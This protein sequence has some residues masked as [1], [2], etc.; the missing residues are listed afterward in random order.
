MKENRG[1]GIGR[2]ASIAASFG[3]A[4]AAL[5]VTGCDRPDR[6]G[7]IA[8]ERA[9]LDPRIECRIGNARQ[10]ERFCTAERDSGEDGPTLT[11]H[12]PDGGFRRLLIT[13]D[14][15]GVVAA[16]GAEP[17]QVTI[18]DGGRIEV[19]IGGDR[20]RLPATIAAQ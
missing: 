9:R 18:I 17:A 12:K 15:R 10:F 13:E 1:I 8:S 4:L 2:H 3:A 16:D 14:G 19:A 11:L 6:L 7:E 20:F 5:L